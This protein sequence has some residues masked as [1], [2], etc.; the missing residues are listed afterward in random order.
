MFQQTS[1]QVLR[2]RIVSLLLG[3]RNEPTGNLEGPGM[4]TMKLKF[5]LTEKGTIET[6]DSPESNLVDRTC[7]VKYDTL[8]HIY[9]HNM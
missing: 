6:L 8:A 4:H 1:D 5:K 3:D 7:H 9:G 2:I